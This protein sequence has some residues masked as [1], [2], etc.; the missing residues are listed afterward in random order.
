MTTDELTKGISEVKSELITQSW[1]HLH[2]QQF[3]DDL[4]YSRTTED[5]ADFSVFRTNKHTWLNFLALFTCLIV[6]KCT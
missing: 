6:T 2:L 3:T 4:W 1:I 5:K